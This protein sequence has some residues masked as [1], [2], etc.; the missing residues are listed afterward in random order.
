MIKEKCRI[1]KY[2]LSLDAT[3]KDGIFVGLCRFNPPV[4][5]PLYNAY[6]GIRGALEGNFPKTHSDDWCGKFKIIEE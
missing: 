3:N 6:S 5:M 2:W 4:L 1:C